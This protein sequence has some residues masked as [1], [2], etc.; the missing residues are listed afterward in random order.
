MNENKLGYYF[1]NEDKILIPYDVNML[2]MQNPINNVYN[3]LLLGFIKSHGDP[4]GRVCTSINRIVNE[5]GYYTK[6]KS[7]IYHKYFKECIQKF[8]DE[9][10]LFLEDD[11]DILSIKNT[12]LFQMT[13]NKDNDIFYIENTFV[14][15]TL[16][17]FNK[18]IGIDCGVKQGIILN[19]FLLFKKYSF[20]ADRDELIYPSKA[21]ITKSL[22]ILST[23]T[24]EKAI[25]AL[26]DVG[27]VFKDKPYFVKNKSN[28]DTY[29]QLRNIYSLSPDNFRYTKHKLEQIYEDKVYSIDDIDKEKIVRLSKRH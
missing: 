28:Q 27:L 4:L 6:S 18:I 13:L 1:M 24:T 11:V 21:S 26:I 25:N 19:T 17:E 5:T 16:E 10:L 29:V 23:K 20:K 22:G 14:T 8:V 2:D 3:L 9:E 15:I 12:D 7:K